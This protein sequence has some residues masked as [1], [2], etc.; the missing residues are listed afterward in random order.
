MPSTHIVCDA[1]TLTLTVEGGLTASV[2]QEL[3]TELLNA[4]SQGAKDI[5]VRLD[6][7]DMVDSSGIGL[8]VAAHNSVKRIGGVLRVTGASPEILHLFKAMRLDQHFPVEGR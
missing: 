1:G 6:Q 8:L 7:C 3:R 5:A 4:V 2:S